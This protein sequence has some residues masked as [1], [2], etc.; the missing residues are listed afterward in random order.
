M[1]SLDATLPTSVGSRPVVFS[2]ELASSNLPTPSKPTR[3]S[4]SR[5]R[6]SKLADAFCALTGPSLASQEINA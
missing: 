4:R 6:V 3:P 5:I 1:S 2:R